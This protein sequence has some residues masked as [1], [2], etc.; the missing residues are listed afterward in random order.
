MSRLFFALWPNAEA[1]RQIAS[2]S[3]QINPG[4]GRRVPVDNLHITLVFLGNIDEKKRGCVL[5]SVD[6]IGCSH[7]DLELDHLGWWK[8]AQ[9]IWL[10]PSS[11]PVEL[12]SLA[13]T[14]ASQADQ[15][16][17]RVDDRP[18]RAH[19]TLARKVRKN[20]HLPAIRPVRWS[21]GKFALIESVN[22]HDG[23]KYEPVWTSA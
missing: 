17:I 4:Y 21:V 5:E 19:M 10:A 1:R 14:L 18:Y 16:G 13:G 15:C 12:E 22:T 6:K 20:P 8:K 3:E 11:I 9:V 7:I 2:I 23:V